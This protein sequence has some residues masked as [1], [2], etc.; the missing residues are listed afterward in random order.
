M[1]TTSKAQSKKGG[2]KRAKKAES[3]S[4]R[5]KKS[6]ASESP[7]KVSSKAAIAGR[8]VSIEACKQ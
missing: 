4:K 8:L 1:V 6:K 7:K 3:P 5:A 2:E